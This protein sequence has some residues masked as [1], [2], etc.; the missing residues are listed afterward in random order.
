ML[1]VLPRNITLILECPALQVTNRLIQL[2]TPCPIYASH[3]SL[4]ASNGHN[5]PA[6]DPF[7][8]LF[9]GTQFRYPRHCDQ[10]QKS[11]RNATVLTFA[12]LSNPPIV[13]IVCMSFSDNTSRCFHQARTAGRRVHSSRRKFDID[14][15]L[16]QRAIFTLDKLLKLFD[17]HRKELYLVCHMSELYLGLVYVVH[18][19]QHDVALAHLR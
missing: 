1:P 12:P 14:K 2:R 3:A 19:L 13:I 6:I 11:R 18:R 9:P 16:H 10:S 15:L 8:S 17:A 7:I 4:P 5:D